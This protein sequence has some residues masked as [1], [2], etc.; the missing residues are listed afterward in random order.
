MKLENVFHYIIY[1]L[2]AGAILFS[3]AEVLFSEFVPE[4]AYFIVIL[5]VLIALHWE[6]GQIKSI[7]DGLDIIDQKMGSTKI[8]I[9]DNSA[10]FYER[11][12]EYAKSAKKELILTHIRQHPPTSFKSGQEYFDWV[13]DWVSGK[14]DVV[15]KRIGGYFKGYTDEWCKEQQR[16]SRDQENYQF[17]CIENSISIVNFAVIDR[18]GLFLSI[19]GETKGE[20]T[21][22]FIEDSK[23]AEQYKA[24]FDFIWQNASN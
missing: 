14:E 21:G 10:D 1:I 24:Y 11:L 8:S 13:N 15:V 12:K 22:Y 5:S 16:E 19:P 17:R 6:S 18:K 4:K 7:K 2:L 3:L 23:L 9:Y 20:T